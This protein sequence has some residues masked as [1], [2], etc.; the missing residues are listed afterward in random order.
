MADKNLSDFER[1]A[2]SKLLEDLG[3]I[4]DHPS[5]KKLD[6]F[7]KK[8]EQEAV[9]IV[10]GKA[11]KSNILDRFKRMISSLVSFTLKREVK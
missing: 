3:R 7:E 11:L 1:G 8:L 2:L 4:F 9:R 5:D 6:A 10:T